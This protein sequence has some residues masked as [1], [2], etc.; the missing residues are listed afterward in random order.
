MSPPA[1]KARALVER[2]ITASTSSASA[3]WRNCSSSPCTMSSVTAFRAFGRF[4]VTT[5]RPPA[6]SNPISSLLNDPSPSLQQAA[7]DDHPHD[8][9]RAFQNLVHARVADVSFQREIL[10]IAVAAVQLHRLVA[11]FE[12]CIG[13]APFRHGSLAPPLRVPGSPPTSDARLG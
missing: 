3:H 6:T 11:D 9:V 8:L 7:G 2:I 13:C 1:A 10:Q 12:S 5:P 4:S